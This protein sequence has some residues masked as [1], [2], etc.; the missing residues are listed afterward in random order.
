LDAEVL[1]TTAVALSW[2][3]ARG[4]KRYRVEWD[5]GSGGADRFL[6]AWVD[7]TSYVDDRLLPGVYR[8]WVTAEG[9]GGL[10]TSA[11][12]VVLVSIK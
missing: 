1:S 3:P 6:R 8:Y 4:A 11:S 10:S 5:S 12:I 9:S 7:E 2:Q